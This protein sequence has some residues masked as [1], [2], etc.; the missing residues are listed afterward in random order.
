MNERRAD[1]YELAEHLAMLAAGESITIPGDVR[2]LYA[3]GARGEISSN[4]IVAAIV[5]R[6]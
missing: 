5:A 1:A 4:A 2:E 3:R 6:Y